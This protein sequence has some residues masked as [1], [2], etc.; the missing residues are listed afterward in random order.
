MGEQNPEVAV[1]DDDYLVPDEIE[2]TDA[3]L[4]FGNDLESPEPEP[5]NEPET[6]DEAEAEEDPETDPAEEEV[7]EEPEEEEEP[8][9]EPEPEKPKKEPFLPKSRFDEVNRKR[10]MAE[11][12]AQELEAKL[13]EIERERAEANRPKPM[14][15]DE[16]KSALT[17]INNLMIDGQIEEAAEK[18]AALF[19]HMQSIQT[20]VSD[21]KEAPDMEA[22]MAQMEERVEFKST[23][24]EVYSQYPQLDDTSETANPEMIEEA[25]AQQNSL[26]QRGYSLAEA[27]KE[28]ARRVAKIY[29]LDQPAETVAYKKEQK[30]RTQ[31]K[32]EAAKKAPPAVPTRETSNDDPGSVD[33][34]RMSDDE[35]DALP[36]SVKARLRGDLI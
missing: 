17:E 10:K 19:A 26:M 2:D 5:A 34:S 3:S 20:A 16:L 27:T 8:E 30:A 36:D 33:L 35:Y 12:R 9:P 4:D 28:A 7:E 1:E 14:E 18:Q 15:S 6:E 31:K 25:V 13:T 24:K 23:L 21:G 32:M 22:M 29:D 11:Q